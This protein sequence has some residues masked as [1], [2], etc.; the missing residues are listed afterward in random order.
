MKQLN[1]NKRAESVARGWQL[2]CMCVGTFPPSY[3]FEY[4]LLRFVLMKSEQGKG[5][6]KDYARYCLRT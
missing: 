4:Y 6:V 2:M 5:A 3:D 1:Q